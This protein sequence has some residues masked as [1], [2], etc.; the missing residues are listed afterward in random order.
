MIKKHPPLVVYFAFSSTSSALYALIFTVNLLYYIFVAKLNPLQLV[1]VGTALEA[2]IFIFEIPTGVVAD[3][4]SRRLSVVIGV[5]LIGI[6]FLVNG[7]WP[8]FW[9][10]L[11]A[12]VLWALGY[13][14]TSGATQA[15]I[16]DEIGEENAGLAFIRGARWDPL[17]QSSHPDRRRSFHCFG[18]LPC[19]FYA[20]I[21]V[22]SG[23]H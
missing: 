17:P 10:I 20:R 22:P 14:F 19:V 21:W 15:W 6:A 12:Q 4:L 1:L 2:S 7:T 5:F 23:G 9:V 11:V 13:T 16:S 3:S 8:V 18:F